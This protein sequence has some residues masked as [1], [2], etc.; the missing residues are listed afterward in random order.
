[1]GRG[2]ICLLVDDL[3]STCDHFIPN[4]HDLVTIF[5]T[6]CW[7][8]DPID[9]EGHFVTTIFQITIASFEFYEHVQ[10][11]YLFIWRRLN[12]LR[13]LSPLYWVLVVPVVDAA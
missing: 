6:T 3:V 13:V 12:L 5:L 1:M 2:Q 8:I 4:G 11:Q 9:R 10:A 7:P